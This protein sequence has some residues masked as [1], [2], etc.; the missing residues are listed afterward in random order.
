MAAAITY[1]TNL[2]PDSITNPDVD[3]SIARDNTT[4]FSFLEFI[5][6]TKVD[7]SPE[8]YN[9]LSQRMRKFIK[10]IYLTYRK[11]N[12]NIILVTHQSL[13]KCALKLNKNIINESIIKNYPIG[14]CCLILDKD[15]WV[16]QE[17]S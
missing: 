14:K 5:T 10:Y 3:F 8:E 11:S 13:C 16:F 1:A 15:K 2:V 6:T 17:I 4:P 12:Y 9:N 7:Y